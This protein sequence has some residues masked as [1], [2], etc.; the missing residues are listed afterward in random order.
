MPPI[1]PIGFLAFGHAVPA[2][3]QTDTHRDNDA[4]LDTDQGAHLFSGVSE[5]RCLDPGERIE[6]LMI[7]AARAALERAGIQPH[8]IDRLYGTALF[9][10]YILPSG[11]FAVHRGLGLDSRVMVVPVETPFTNFVT[12]AVL[13]WEAILAGRAEYVLVCC[14]SALT[15]NLDSDK[16]EARFVGDGAGA[17][18][19]GP[20]GQW[21]IVDA[22][23]STFS[24]DEGYRG[25]T[26]EIR[27][28][29]GGRSER[30]V[31]VYCIGAGGMETLR[32]RGVEEPPRLLLQMLERHGIR[33]SRIALVAHHC[34]KPVSDAWARAI[35]P[36]QVLTTID[37]VGDVTMAAI[38][39]TLATCIDALS[40]E[41]VAM[42]AVGIGSHFSVLLARRREAER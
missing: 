36:A 4:A 37:R 14:G 16:P 15:R 22:M 25:F 34:P 19:L 28:P 20:R 8:A 1:S 3:V 24:D 7:V 40:V 32:R 38:P 9:G 33:A 11:L 5:R 10:D 41:Y 29:V 2:R 42:L 39:I 23:T 12:S 27:T 21:A 30:P 13:G 6:D 26:M 35:A 18:V 17:A 31:P